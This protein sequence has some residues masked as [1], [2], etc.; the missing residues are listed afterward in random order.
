MVE[1][2]ITLFTSII[3]FLTIIIILFHFK[4]NRLANIYLV[5]IFATISLRF[6]VIGYLSLTK[7]NLLVGILDTINS[8]LILIFPLAY[9]Y[10]KNLIIDE[11]K[12][13]LQNIKHFIVSIIIITLDIADD[14][15][16]IVIPYKPFLLIP[17]VS[18]YLLG[19]FILIYRLLNKNIWQR[20]G[21]I[22]I[23]I[24][25]NKLIKKWTIYLFLLFFLA[26]VRL[27]ISLLFEILNNQQP[28]GVKQL[29]I[30]SLIWLGVF[31]NILLSPEILYGYG[32]LLKKIDTY[33]NSD[34]LIKS[35]WNTKLLTEISNIQDIKLNNK[36]SSEILD[37]IFKVDSL[38]I[39]ENN[40]MNSNFTLSDL[41]KILNIKQS[42]LLFL[43]KYHS[44]ISFPEYKKII[45]IKESILL[46]ENNYLKKDTL[47]SL[48]RK[49]GF[50]SYNTFFVSFKDVT[51]VNPI[52][53]GKKN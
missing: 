6:F 51:G 27:I 7:N 15:N 42:H 40:F 4:T 34:V 28:F 26:S 14:Y 12:I 24:K 20:K 30:S 9:L 2:L 50:I 39:D 41:G 29:W 13:Q 10:F 22:K 46:I 44:K 31:L 52:E 35:F 32:H 11:K 5:L 47:D 8:S 49:V 38:T 17:F 18:I 16:Y 53:Y 43:F 21:K 48:A 25:Q 1:N 23:V 37:Y 33:N 3:G 19:Y 45:R 36:I